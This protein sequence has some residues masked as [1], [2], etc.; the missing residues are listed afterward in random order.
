MG[1]KCSRGLAL[2]IRNEKLG[3]L[4]SLVL[5]VLKNWFWY[6]VTYHE[7]NTSNHSI[8]CKNMC[9]MNAQKERGNGSKNF[10]TRITRF[11]V[12]V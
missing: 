10:G 3:L 2:L 1:A 4:E 8:N 12:V 7:A 6:N 11:G 9:Y 5:E